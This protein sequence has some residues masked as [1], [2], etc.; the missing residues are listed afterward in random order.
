MEYSLERV[1]D[2]ER[3][4]KGERFPDDPPLS[5]PDAPHGTVVGEV[6]DSPEQRAFVLQAFAYRKRGLPYSQIAELTGRTEREAQQ[7]V[8]KRLKELEFDE[9]SE[10]GTARRMMLEQIDSMIAAITVPATGLDIDGNPVPVHPKEM[11]EAI[12]R[13]VKLF[14]Q[15]AK[16]LGINAPQRI[17]LSHRIELLAQT[18]GYDLQELQ[19]I[20]A[21]VVAGYNPAKLR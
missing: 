10:A 15:K 16:L 6:M 9:L 17:D 14:E 5:G 4:R 20:T 3:Q 18:S 1:R 7:A 8:V 12:D 13:M 2:V 19:Q 11:L 21:E